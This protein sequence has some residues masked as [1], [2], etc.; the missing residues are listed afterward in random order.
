ML[1][2]NFYRRN[3]D[4]NVLHVAKDDD[5]KGFIKKTLTASLI[6][7]DS[8]F[9][10]QA[11]KEQP[12]PPEKGK[13]CNFLS[14]LL[15]FFS[16]IWSPYCMTCLEFR[17]WIFFFFFCGNSSWNCDI[18][19]IFFLQVCPPLCQLLAHL[20]FWANFLF[21]FFLFFII[22]TQALFKFQ[23]LVMSNYTFWNL[24]V[25]QCQPDSWRTNHTNSRMLRSRL[26]GGNGPSVAA[27]FVHKP[28]WWHCMMDRCKKKILMCITQ[29]PPGTQSVV[30]KVSQVLLFIFPHK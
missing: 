18:V 9:A 16:L 23:W 8:L 5:C 12:N 29:E 1:S 11:L 20:S 7:F 6:S 27:L 21:F 4:S 13:V 10:S 19:I 24:L 3:T 15:S 30:I 25:Q 22:D 17:W 14:L 2:A 28:S 26:R